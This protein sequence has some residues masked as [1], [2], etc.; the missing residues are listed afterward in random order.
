MMRQYLTRLTGYKFQQFSDNPY[1]LMAMS[2][3]FVMLIGSILLSL[4]IATKSGISTNYTDALFTAVSAVG[5]TGLAV[6]DTYEHWSVFGQV[7]IGILIQLGG[8]G[9]MTF[10]TLIAAVLGRR[11]GLRDRLVLQEAMGQSG[12][13]G[14]V[15]LVLRIVKF[16]FAIEFIGGVVY[17]YQLYEYLGV[18]SVY[19]GFL[20]AIST[21][22]NAGFVF[23]DSSLPYMMVG[24]WLFTLNSCIMI[25]VSG[26]GFTVIFDVLKNYRRG[27]V[28]L[29]LHS[30]VILWG[31][32]WLLFISF[33]MI[34]FLEWNNVA[35]MGEMTINNKIEAAFFQSAASRTA[36]IA[37]LDIGAMRPTTL[38]VEMLM[39]FIGGGPTST[40]GGVKISTIVVV[41]VAALAVF[42][43]KTEVE[44]YER[45]IPHPVVYRAIGTI[46]FSI[47]IILVGTFIIA[48]IEPFDFI[49]IL[50]EV[51]SA[52]GTVGLTT[53]ITEELSAGSKWVLIFIMYAG[54]VGIL[55]LLGSLAMKDHGKARITYP[56]GHVI[57]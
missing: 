44:L 22:C 40:A 46:L 27:M 2:F 42:R 9:I 54:R 5:V 4:P 26:V 57:I 20:Q 30:K 49:G 55:T 23:F 45:R 12:M 19:Y 52:L 41:F 37:T 7:V 24:N 3:A 6:V 48:A 10:S 53:G 15:K 35:T 36:G 32:F 56:E 28:Y 25:I 38:M 47:S 33:V 29:T 39:M 16:T 21:F 8:L 13:H 43:G 1:R 11:I 18:A 17:S 50:F 34:L 31:T 51:T 14:M